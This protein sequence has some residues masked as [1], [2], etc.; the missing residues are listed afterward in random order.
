MK[1]FLRILLIYLFFSSNSFADDY[2]RYKIVESEAANSLLE[3]AEIKKLVEKGDKDEAL[4]KIEAHMDY[5]MSILRA[6]AQ[7][8]KLSQQTLMILK[9]SKLNSGDIYGSPRIEKD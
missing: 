4:K 8:Q 9:A 5:R 1:I 6:I 7:D 3:Y 2:Q